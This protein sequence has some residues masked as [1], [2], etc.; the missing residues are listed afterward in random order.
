MPSLLSKQDTH[1]QDGIELAQLL[2][3]ARPVLFQ[4]IQR[5]QQLVWL[6]PVAV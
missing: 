2:L 1:R 3:S 6:H 4:P 5:R